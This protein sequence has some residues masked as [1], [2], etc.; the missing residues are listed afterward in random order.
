MKQSLLMALLMVMGTLTT[1]AAKKKTK[2]TS[3][4]QSTALEIVT[5]VNNHYQQTH[6][7]ET[8]AF[9]DDAVYHT[10]NME[11]YR[12]TGRAQWLEYSD[13]WARYNRW[14]GA[15]CGN[16]RM[17]TNN[18]QTYGEDNHHVLFADWQTCFQ[19]YLDLNELNPAAHKVSRVSDVMNFQANLVQK[20]FWWWCDALYMAMP[21]YAKLYRQTGNQSYLVAMNRSFQWTDSLL[22]DADSHLYYRDAKYVYPA[23]RT[24]QGKKD[25]WA[26]GNGWVMAALVKV[27]QDIPTSHPYY[28]AYKERLQQMAGA[29]AGCQQKEGYWTRSMLDARQ[30]EGCE[31]SGTALICY[32]LL[33]G[34]N[35]GVLDT[36]TFE[37]VAKQAWHYLATTALQADGSV[38]YVQPVGESAVKGQK[39]T[40]QNTSNFGMGAFLLA[41]CEK[42]RYDA[43]HQ[44]KTNAVEVVVSNDENVFR[45]EVVELDVHTIF[46]RLGIEGGRQVRVINALNQEIPYQLT[47]DGKMLIEVALRPCGTAKYRIE[48]GTP[49]PTVNTVYGRMYPERVDDI[50]WENDRGAYRLYGP[51]LQRS[52]ERAFGNDVWLKNTPDLEVESRY[53]VELANHPKIEK[54]RKEGKESEAKALEEKTTYHFDHGHGLDCYKVGPSL[55]CGA[56]ALMIGDSIVFPYS[57]KEYELLDNGPLR[58]TVK[59]T[60]HPTTIDGQQVTEHRLLSLDKGSNFNKQ[61]VWYDGATKSLDVAS[62]VVIHSEDTKNWSLGSNSVEYADPTDN[63]N[64]QNFQIYVGV[65][66]PEGG[67]ETKYVESKG[68]GIV[69]HALC[70][71]RSLAPGEKLTYYWGSAWSKYDIR[72]QQAWRQHIIDRQNALQC[73]LEVTYSE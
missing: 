12:L 19:T 22:Y 53:Y 24:E 33:W 44:A 55:G 35:Q 72:N 17:W 52:G 21:V 38:G 28:K 36:A 20:D 73:P 41:A 61:T 9:W 37:P 57:Y 64:G 67:C 58:F 10:G 15:R 6:S 26:R 7:P 27:M 13:R 43:Q 30:V 46:G 60:Y 69:G 25:F 32:A 65:F 50:A 4:E 56:P 14:S 42:A 71:K 62:G 1:Q 11:A 51:A 70:I 23:H 48:R 66:F 3:A 54:L 8:R 5:R 68:P 16:K 47:Y 49:R 34:I 59:L 40:A 63:P 45:Q 18:Y 31:T 2:A 29:V 39:L